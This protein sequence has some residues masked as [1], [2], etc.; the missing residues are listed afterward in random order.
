[1]IRAAIIALMLAG[2]ASHNMK[3]TYAHGDIDRDGCIA[4]RC[5]MYCKAGA[6]VTLAQCQA[7]VTQ[8]DVS[9]DDPWVAMAR[10]GLQ[11]VRVPL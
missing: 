1:M 4:Y 6:P 8:S 7:L 11:L 5:Q 3:D 9:G 2:C 10:R